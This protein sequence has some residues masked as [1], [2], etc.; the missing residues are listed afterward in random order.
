M[1]IIKMKQNREMKKM[2]KTTIDIVYYSVCAIAFIASFAIG[3]MQ[4][5]KQKNIIASI[6]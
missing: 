3:V 2:T 1:Q 5:A 6:V 4:R